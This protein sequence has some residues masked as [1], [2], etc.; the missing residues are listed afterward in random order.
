MVLDNLLFFIVSTFSFYFLIKKKFFFYE[1]FLDKDFLKPQAF[2]KVPTPRAGGIIIFLIS[3]FYSIFLQPLKSFSY[4]IILLGA[5][6]FI[7]GFFEDFRFKLKAGIRL[8]IMFILSL[9]ITY[10]LEIKIEHT[11]FKFLDNL[12]NLNRLTSSLFVC[13]CLLFIVNGSNFID[14]FNGLLTFQYI[15]ILI[16]LYFLIY[17]FEN[18]YYLSNY[19]L[20]SIVLGFSFLIFNFPFGKIFLG[21]SGAYFLGANLSLIIIEI[22]H[23][24]P[25]TKFSPV[26]FACL[27]FY[28]FFEVFFSF[29]RKSFFKK[30]SPLNP[31]KEHLHMYLFFFIKSKIGNNLK[32]NYLTSLTVN[33]FY[34]FLII[35]VFLIYDDG[36][37]CKIYFAVLV[38]FYLISY[39]L[40][41]IRK[42]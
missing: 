22:N 3:L 30:V 4:S 14:G 1:I 31:D 6:F 36:Y 24:S 28:L 5:L 35:P 23:L 39:F 41:K 7:I 9:L 13:F 29:C 25:Y 33:L 32:S 18:F 27:L 37:K 38:F 16:I 20:L 17:K 8:A 12:I 21:D 34:F 2:H 19:I 15:I 11:Q 40:L 10:F 42:S 26:V